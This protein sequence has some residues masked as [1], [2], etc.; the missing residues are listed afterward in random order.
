MVVA[1][2]CFIKM[3]P[4]SSAPVRANAGTQMGDLHGRLRQFRRHVDI[5]SVVQGVD[6]FCRWMC[7]SPAAHPP[8]AFYKA[9]TLLQDSIG[10]ERR[11]ALLGSG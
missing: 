8:E 5:Y 2:T 6:K 10:K 7:I 4:L 9:L 11:P 1:G 3:A